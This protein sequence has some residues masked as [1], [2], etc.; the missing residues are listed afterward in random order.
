MYLTVIYLVEIV[1]R[2]DLM[3]RTG[4]IAIYKDRSIN[5]FLTN[6]KKEIEVDLNKN[7]YKFGDRFKYFE[8]KEGIVSFIDL[9]NLDELIR[10]ISVANSIHVYA[11]FS[12]DKHSKMKKISLRKVKSVDN[13]CFVFS[14]GYKGFY[15][16][17]IFSE[18]IPAIL[19]SLRL[20]NSQ[21]LN[22]D[23]SFMIKYYEDQER[24]IE[25]KHYRSVSE[26]FMTLKNVLIK[27]EIV[28]QD[29]LNLKDNDH[30]E[31]LDTERY[32]LETYN[33]M[34]DLYNVLRA[35]MICCFNLNSTEFEYTRPED[36]SLKISKVLVIDIINK[37][38]GRKEM[39]DNNYTINLYDFQDNLIRGNVKNYTVNGSLFFIYADYK[40]ACFKSILIEK[41]DEY[42]A[43]LVY[44]YHNNEFTRRILYFS[45]I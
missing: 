26:A 45:E 28:V 7:T 32:Y 3:A 10:N 31:T 30:S 29:I 38:T 12:D 9:P 19:L 36:H 8:G 21:C 15:S 41:E 22:L 34:F 40:Q 1:C 6:S 23:E 25:L 13:E 5:G 35:Y 20:L 39:I 37:E 11:T 17:R 27:K 2:V 42:Q 24:F 4:W 18:I 33:I 44:N 14:P 16:A 43:V